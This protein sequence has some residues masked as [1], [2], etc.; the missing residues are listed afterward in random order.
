MTNTAKGQILGGA[1]LS[2]ISVSASSSADEFAIK[3]EPSDLHGAI[4]LDSVAD[5]DGTTTVR[6]I[7]DYRPSTSYTAVTSWR[8][9][10]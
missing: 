1:V 10:E 8:V 4:Q 9:V 7:V 2:S 6:S 5:R 3:V